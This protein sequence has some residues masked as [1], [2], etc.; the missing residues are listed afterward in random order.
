MAI[1]GTQGCEDMCKERSCCFLSAETSIDKSQASISEPSCANNPALK[2]WCEEYSACHILLLPQTITGTSGNNNYHYTKTHSP[3]ANEDIPQ[4]TTTSMD[5]VTALSSA[6]QDAAAATAAD[7]VN[8]ACASDYVQINGK[9]SCQEL[10]A[11]RACCFTEGPFSCQ[12]ELPGWCSQYSA[13]NILTNDNQQQKT[14]TTTSTS[15]NA[16]VTQACSPAALQL[17]KAECQD[18][19]DDRACCFAAGSFNCREELRDWCHEYSACH[20]LIELEVEQHLI[21]NDLTSVN[22]FQ[23]DEICDSSKMQQDS[24]YA[25]QC[26]KLC[27][28]RSCCFEANGSDYNCYTLNSQ[29]CDEFQ[30][31]WNLPQYKDTSPTPISTDGG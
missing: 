22:I 26:T 8:S 17:S 18:L 16:A 11:D 14:T 19:C 28:T 23:V 31:C 5:S 4:N 7:A 10:C 29:W 3:L 13:C 20:A 15:S 27:F 9:H 30:S 6:V 21:P 12:K 1:N 2:G 25:S 24:L